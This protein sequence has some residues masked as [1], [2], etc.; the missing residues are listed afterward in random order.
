MLIFFVF[1]FLILTS[2]PSAFPAPAP[3][4][5]MSGNS[6]TPVGTKAAFSSAPF[7]ITKLPYWTP[8]PPLPSVRAAA[9]PIELELELPLIS[10]AFES[11]DA[12]APVVVPLLMLPTRELRSSIPAQEKSSEQAR[13]Q[14]FNTT[15]DPC[16]SV[17]FVDFMFCFGVKI[18]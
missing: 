15:G 4:T 1:S 6:A 2:S 10:K 3:V 8:L 13:L 16:V 5:G 18:D 12:G 11:G 14:L 17:H 7:P 9:R